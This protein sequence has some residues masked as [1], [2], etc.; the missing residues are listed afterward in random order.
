MTEI[1]RRTI[2][3]IPVHIRMLETQSTYFGGFLKSNG[4]LAKKDNENFSILQFQSFPLLRCC[5]ANFKF[6]SHTINSKYFWFPFE[7]P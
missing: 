1:A 7:L 3:H 5:N 2:N 4:Q 6:I